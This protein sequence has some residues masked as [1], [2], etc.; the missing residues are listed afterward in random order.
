MVGEVLTQTWTGVTVTTG[1]TTLATHTSVGVGNYLA[2]IEADATKATATRQITAFGGT[3]TTTVVK[4]ALGGDFV[5][6]LD[7]T[8]VSLY[9]SY[10]FRVTVAGSVTLTSTAV[11]ASTTSNRGSFSLIRIS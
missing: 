2:V 1:G 4:S 7:S 8:S 10:Y 11:T 9:V 3:A 5:N 6:T